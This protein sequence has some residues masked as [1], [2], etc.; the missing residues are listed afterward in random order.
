[1]FDAEYLYIRG[2]SAVHHVS[3]LRKGDPSPVITIHRMNKALFFQCV[4]LG[5]RLSLRGQMA[6][7]FF[8]QG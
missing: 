5:L 8:Q 4:I 7:W 2:T 1:M 6:F 3:V